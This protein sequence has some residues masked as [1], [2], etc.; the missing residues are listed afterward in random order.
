MNANKNK[1][2][3]TLKF[4]N[5]TILLSPE[6]A[7]RIGFYKLHIIVIKLILWFTWYDDQTIKVFTH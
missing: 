5:N 2:L 4:E 7:T 6:L 3:N 1:L